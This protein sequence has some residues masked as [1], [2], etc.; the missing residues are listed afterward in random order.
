MPSFN[1][2]EKIKQELLHAQ[3]L[4]TD[5]AA[6]LEHQTFATS[7]DLFT[8]VSQQ[9]DRPEAEVFAAIGA[10]IDFPV[11]DLRSKT[12]DPTILN[13]IP[14]A[15]AQRYHCIAFDRQDKTVMI[16]LTDPY[17]F[18]AVEALEFLAKQQKTQIQYALISAGA[19]GEALG[20]YAQFDQEVKVALAAVE[21]ERQ[22]ASGEDVHAVTEI[23][24]VI[25]QA[26][27]A[28]IV[29]EI[30]RHALH[31]RASDIHIEPAREGSRVRLRVDGVLQTSLQLPAHV[32]ASI[33]SRV[34][35]LA[36]LRLDETRVPQDGRITV[37][38]DDQRVDFRVSTM[39]LLEKEKVVLRI[40]KTSEAVPTLEDLGFH[41]FHITALE[42]NI[43]RP[44]GLL[45][46]SG[47][48]GSGKSTTLYSLLSLLN[49]VGSNIV[50]L[51]DPV[52]FSIPGVNQSQIRPEVKFTFASGLRALLRQDPDIIMVGEIRDG[53]TANMAIHAGL[54][55]HLI[56][57]TI[58]TN[59]AIGVVPRLIDMGVE[60]FLLA[61]TLNAM[62][63][64]RLVR[65]VCPR[66]VKPVQL[67]DY[68]RTELQTE[69][70]R[71]PPEYIPTGVNVR[72]PEFV[73][74]RGCDACGQTGYAGRLAIAEIIEATEVLRQL[75]V[76][77]YTSE[78][79]SAEMVRQKAITLMQDGLLRAVEGQTTVDEVLR[80]TKE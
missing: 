38:L 34:K 42:K 31:Q 74:G 27:V 78:A 56:F 7:S 14:F 70:D 28:K 25:A 52:E 72:Q 36:N 20:Q 41:K 44:H 35:V 9:S 66:C 40:L 64:Q 4:S 2:Y 18:R 16:G 73:K 51:E 48:T 13:L 5:A 43:A 12:I 1:G 33:I 29:A 68:L 15:T 23:E 37:S 32:H 63:A 60:P 8:W 19:F 79:V 49:N 71:I 11:A 77:K 62:V 76:T 53:Q 30:M 24:Q 39:P 55:G 3:V 59:D 50:T 45:L 6:L 46:I 61:S 69:L 21:T 10:A 80:A 17:D 65:R 67:P 22:A 47:P 58:H 26:P 75:V 54:T 57:S